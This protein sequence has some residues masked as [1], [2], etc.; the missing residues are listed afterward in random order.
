MQQDSVPVCS[1]TTNSAQRLSGLRLRRQSEV[2]PEHD[3]PSLLDG[4]DP[5]VRAWRITQNW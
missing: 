5:F 3:E 4:Q 2:L 1:L